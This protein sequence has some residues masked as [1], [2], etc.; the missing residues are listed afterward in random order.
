MVGFV[1][2]VI[3]AECAL[4]GVVVVES[5]EVPTE[6]RNVSSI[7]S[8]GRPVI[9]RLP[10]SV[11]ATQRGGQGQPRDVF[12][13][14]TALSQNTPKTATLMVTQVRRHGM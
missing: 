2:V 7:T 13:I 9:S 12:A 14:G 5:T 8:D 10:L 6:V 4:V 1:V 11:M 3:A